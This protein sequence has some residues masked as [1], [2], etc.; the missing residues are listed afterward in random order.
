MTSEDNKF[1]NGKI[2]RIV[3]DDDSKTYYGRTTLP[4]SY[5]MS[6]HKAYWK[7]F[8]NGKGNFLSAFEIFDEF[9]FE[10]IRIE[11]VELYPCNSKQE[12]KQRERHY[13]ESNI[14][15]NRFIPSRLK[16]ETYKIWA[17]NNIDRVREIGRESYYRRIDK[18]T[19][20]VR[21]KVECS[22][23]KKM[24]CRDCLSRHIKMM[25]T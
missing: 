9:G 19:A 16:S 1:K 5:R 18:N 10:K 6:Y 24:L 12:L 25:H 2:Y 15:V 11:L 14:C 3:S 13:I 20:R 17:K 21:E 22:I 23:C 8:K 7:T 4:L